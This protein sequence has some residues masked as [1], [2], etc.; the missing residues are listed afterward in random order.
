MSGG[1]KGRG[2]HLH[3]EVQ[4]YMGRQSRGAVSED[5]ESHT[6]STGDHLGGVHAMGEA[7]E[8]HGEAEKN[9][10]WLWSG[11]RET[12]ARPLWGLAR[13]LLWVSSL[14]ANNTFPPVPFRLS[15]CPWKTQEE[16]RA[17]SS[18]GVQEEGCFCFWVLSA[19]LCCL[20]KGK[21]TR[22]GKQEVHHLQKKYSPCPPPKSPNPKQTS[23]SNPPGVHK[24]LP[25]WICCLF[26]GQN[27]LETPRNSTQ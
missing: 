26:P 2:A 19:L 11:S 14:L 9:A 3:T 12:L 5:E 8:D 6:W 17:W 4:M 25:E 21:G 13:G 1:E 15:H 18:C 20:Q 27:P 16:G 23:N 24:R 10:Q 22:E 7:A